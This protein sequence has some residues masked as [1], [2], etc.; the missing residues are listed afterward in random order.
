VAEVV[1]DYGQGIPAWISQLAQVC[2]RSW[3]RREAQWF[4]RRWETYVADPVAA[5][6]WSRGK[7]DPG[8][9][10]SGGSSPDKAGT[11]QYCQV[12]RVWRARRR[13][14]REEPV[15]DTPL[16]RHQLKSGGYGLGAARTCP[17]V[18]AGNSRG[19]GH[20]LPGRLRGKTAAYSQRTR[21]GI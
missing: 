10:G 5:G 9:A 21:R 13:G 6:R 12:V 20:E 15:C 19:G 17:D 4:E 1:L 16:M 11:G 2:L 8:G 3:V 18:R 14:V 7:P